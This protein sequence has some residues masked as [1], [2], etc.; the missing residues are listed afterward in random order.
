MGCPVGLR[1]YLVAACWGPVSRVISFPS[2]LLSRGTQGVLRG[3]LC[4]TAMSS[5]SAAAAPL[6]P[7]SLQSISAGF[8]V[9][10][11]YKTHFWILRFFLLLCWLL[12]YH[13]IFRK[14]KTGSQITLSLLSKN[15][16]SQMY[17]AR[18]ILKG[19]GC[20][21]SLICLPENRMLAQWLGRTWHSLKQTRVCFSA[22]L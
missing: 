2:A 8:F 14:L 18:E 13:W 10:I 20:D 21:C 4:L 19:Q 9:S 12:H 16:C 7:S 3:V 11:K 6:Y 5:C 17:K 1:T 22:Y 15:S